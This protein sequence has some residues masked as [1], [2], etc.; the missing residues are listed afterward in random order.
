MNNGKLRIFWNSVITQ[1]CKTVHLNG[2]TFSPTSEF[3][4]TVVIVITDDKDLEIQR[5]CWQWYD[6][7]TRFHEILL[8]Y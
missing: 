1:K 8:F 4:T 6:I 7:H 2:D 5:G 3:H